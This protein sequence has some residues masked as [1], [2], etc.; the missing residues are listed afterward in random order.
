MCEYGCVNIVLLAPGRFSRYGVLYR[1]SLDLSDWVDWAPAVIN[2][3][4]TR[5]LLG[6]KYLCKYVPLVAHKC[7]SVSY[8]DN[9]T[10]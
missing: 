1:V 2:N 8:N 3:Y 4:V 9:S 5:T 7:P 6:R 10:D